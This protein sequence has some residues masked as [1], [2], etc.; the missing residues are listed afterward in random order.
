[1][2]TILIMDDTAI[3]AELIADKFVTAGHQTRWTA[4]ARALVWLWQG[5]GGK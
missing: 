3:L 5:Y 1:M 4:G 2:A